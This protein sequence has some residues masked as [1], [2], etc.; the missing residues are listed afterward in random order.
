MPSRIIVDIGH[1]A[2]VHLFRHVLD[3]WKHDGIETLV[4][5]RDKDITLRLL[6]IYGIPFR[7]TGRAGRGLP[8]QL[9]EFVR[10]E[11]AMFGLVRR[12]RPAIITGTSPNAVRA[13]RLYGAKSVILCEDDAKYIPLFR[14]VAYPWASAIV[15]PDALIHEDYGD[16]HLRYPSYQ[17]LFYL[18]PTRFTPDRGILR[19]LGIG[20][21]ERFGLI[22][23]SA[24][25]AHH[26]RGMTG[27]SEDLVR[28][29]I[30]LVEGDMRVF[31]TSEKP[32]PA[33]FEPHRLP[34]SAERVHHALAFAEFFLGDSQS[35]TV[36]SALLGTPA[37]KINTFAGIISVIRQ[38]EE[39]G[40]AYGYR[41]GEEDALVRQLQEVLAMPDRREH[42]QRLRQRMLSEKIDPL[43]WF[44]A[45]TRK[46]LEGVPVGEVK[47]WS[48][49]ALRSGGFASGHHGVI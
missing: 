17:K 41:P 16:R 38:L 11:A 28:R 9:C 19:E 33:E 44:L 23:L 47:T 34:I 25:T 27:M 1:P 4:V 46:L 36:E 21:S 18:H 10:R 35:M 32:L 49:A 26:D 2:H 7:S 22:R 6:D 48:D 13:A 24:L 8:A 37:F 14:Y 5:A 45:V 40:L 15:T 31:I 20:D 30:R 12:L 39:Y 29:V 3:Q 43:P 42:L